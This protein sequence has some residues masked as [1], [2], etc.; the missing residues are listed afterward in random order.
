MLAVLLIFSVA[1]QYFRLWRARKKIDKE[2]K[3]I[4]RRRFGEGKLK[5]D[6]QGPF[7]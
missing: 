7:G 4:R 6:L 5:Y 2:L 1:F 3:K